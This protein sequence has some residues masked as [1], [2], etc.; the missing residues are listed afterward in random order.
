MLSAFIYM[1]HHLSTM[2]IN[3]QPC[4]IMHLNISDTTTLL[5]YI[6]CYITLCLIGND[7]NAA[8][9]GRLEIRLEISERSP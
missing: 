2:N 3:T 8:Q 6:N 5:G 9:L 7:G 1:A 4:Y